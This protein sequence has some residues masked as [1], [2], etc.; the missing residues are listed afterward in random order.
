MKRLFFSLLFFWLSAGFTQQGPPK[1]S[2]FV[3]TRVELVNFYGD[4]ILYSRS[5]PGKQLIAYDNVTGNYSFDTKL[6]TLGS[7]FGFQLGADA[8]ITKQSRI[9]YSYSHG[10]WSEMVVKVTPSPA[11]V[12]TFFNS[13]VSRTQ[14][15]FSS[16]FVDN[17]LNYEY[18]IVTGLAVFGGFRF[19]YQSEDMQIFQSFPDA[20]SNLNYQVRTFNRMGVLQIGGSISATIKQLIQLDVLFKFGSGVNFAKQKSNA[21]LLPYFSISKSIDSRQQGLFCLETGLMAKYQI[22]ENLFIR[23]GYDT[24]FLSGITGSVNNLSQTPL[25]STQ[26]GTQGLTDIEINTSGQIIYT[27][28]SVGVEYRW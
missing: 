26:L 8:F 2:L 16:K 11:V 27:K 20:G 7:R 15:T 10:H 6:L 24:L 28:S 12:S 3:P 14:S 9:F 18:L 19:L 17:E 5:N 13:H 21:E 1:I 25:R 22:T 23:G 4:G